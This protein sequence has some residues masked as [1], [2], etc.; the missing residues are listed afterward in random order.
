M[1]VGF[2]PFLRHAEKQPLLAHSCLQLLANLLAQTA[3]FN[4]LDQVGLPLLD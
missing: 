3:I 1:P 2:N 4:Q